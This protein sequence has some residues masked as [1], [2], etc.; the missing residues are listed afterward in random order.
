MRPALLIVALNLIAM[1]LPGAPAP[2]PAKKPAE[3]PFAVTAGDWEMDWGCT[4]A[5]MPLAA[6][7]V[8]GW[9]GWS[10]CWRWEPQLNRFHVSEQCG[11]GGTWY[12]WHADLDA[13]GRG[14]VEGN[15]QGVRIHVRRRAAEFLKPP[16]PTD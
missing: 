11:E 2:K 3:T 15:F 16:R 14:T 9:N 12:H 8:Y 4:G 6:D 13:A 1:L 10:G 5:A 7:G